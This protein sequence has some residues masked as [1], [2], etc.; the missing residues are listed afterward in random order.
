MKRR[1]ARPARWPTLLAGSA[2]ATAIA[3]PSSHVWAVPVRC[4]IPPSGI[5]LRSISNGHHSRSTTPRKE[6]L[7]PE[8]ERM[9]QLIRDCDNELAEMDLIDCLPER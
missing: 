1:A 3:R 8:A 7:L 6:G 5:R 2:S 9:K 4:R